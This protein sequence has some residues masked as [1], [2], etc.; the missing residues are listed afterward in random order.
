M[1][2]V[3]NFLLFG[4]DAQQ[5][6]TMQNLFKN[7]NCLRIQDDPKCLAAYPKTAVY[8]DLHIFSL[9]YGLTIYKDFISSNFGH[10]VTTNSTGLQ[11]Y[12]TYYNYMEKVDTGK[13]IS[14][15]LCVLSDLPLYKLQRSLL[16]QIVS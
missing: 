12:G 5:L 8:N 11:K 7:Q 1:K 10:F 16:S 3:S 9:P 6:V 13:Y 15:S 14:K 4:P 2:P